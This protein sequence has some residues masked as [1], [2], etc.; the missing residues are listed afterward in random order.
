[1]IL[2]D[3]FALIGVAAE[4]DRLSSAALDL[5][6]KSDA[7]LHVSSISMLEIGFAVQ[8]RRLELDLP[9]RD[10]FASAL[11][12]YEIRVIDVSWEIA[13][14]SQELPPIHADPADRI[15]ISTAMLNDLTLLTPDRDMQKYP[16][17]KVV[18]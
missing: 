18:W 6:E 17:I 9:P 8:K 5:L 12:T 3:T 16:S 10:W 13:A 14:A 4:R 2:L 11:R 1:M 7:Q 15:I